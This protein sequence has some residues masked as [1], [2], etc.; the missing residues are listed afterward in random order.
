MLEPW[1]FGVGQNFALKQDRILFFALRLM[2]LYLLELQSTNFA[3]FE[4]NLI[5]LDHADK[6]H[7]KPQYAIL[8][9]VE[10]LKVLAKKSCTHLANLSSPLT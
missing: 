1:Y 4:V 8:A 10:N 2:R 3:C 9:L 6:I 7:P 5:L